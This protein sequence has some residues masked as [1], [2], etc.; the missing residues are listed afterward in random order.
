MSYVEL[1]IMKTGETVFTVTYFSNLLGVHRTTVTRCIH[2]GK[3]KDKKFFRVYLI[4]R[5][6]ILIF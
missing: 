6:D 4:E 2:E 1:K 5:P 3:L